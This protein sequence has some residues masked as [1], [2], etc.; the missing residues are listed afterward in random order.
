MGP[1]LTRKEVESFALQTLDCVERKMHCHAER[2]N[3]VI[4][5]LCIISI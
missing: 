3:I 1:Q 4:N 5:Y 2:Q